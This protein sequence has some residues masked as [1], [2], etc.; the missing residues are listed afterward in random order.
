MYQF[1]QPDPAG[2]LRVEVFLGK[3]YVVGAGMII[4]VTSSMEAYQLFNSMPKWMKEEK[5]DN[6]SSGSN[7]LSS[8]DDIIHNVSSNIGAKPYLVGGAVRDAVLGRPSK[9]IDMV[10][11]GNHDLEKMGWEKT[12]N[13]F[14]VYR[15]KKFPDVEVALARS[16][17]Q[18]G[19]GHTGFSWSLAPD[20]ETDLKRRDLTIN[21][22]AYHPSNGI[23]DPHGG[24]HDLQNKKIRHVSDAFS[25]DP[26]RPY[27]VARF[28][29]QLGFDVH[30]STIQKMRDMSHTST[31]LPYNRVQQE[32]NKAM[33][34]KHPH[35]YFEVLSTAGS[36]NSWHPEV[37]NLKHRQSTLS[38]RNGFEDLVSSLKK[39]GELNHPVSTKSLIVT[40]QMTHDEISSHVNRLGL[41]NKKDYI[42]HSL[43]HVIP[44]LF[45]NK[46]DSKEKVEYLTRIKGIADDHFRAAEASSSGDNSISHH[47]ENFEKYKSVRIPKNTSVPQIREL[48]RKALE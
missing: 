1:D 11:V 40:Q 9:D 34:S 33:S 27:R 5:D 43:H 19:R 12:G 21:S 14:P 29:S 39:A 13:L 31:E 26:L 42:N 35:K 17:K 23:I 16:E 47:K 32:Y 2:P 37:E 10:V 6:V 3:Y 38:S 45:S 20:V 7:V 24:M 44:H 48:Q 18:T 28:A 8:Y 46:L 15:N 25:E 22:M 41:G 30:H 36:L 4:P